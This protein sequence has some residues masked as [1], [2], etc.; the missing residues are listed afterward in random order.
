MDCSPPGSSV[1]GI[2]QARILEWVAMLS[3]KESSWTWGWTHLSC[4]FCIGRQIFY[5][6]VTEE[7]HH[8]PSDFPGGSDKPRKHMKKQRHYYLANIVKPLV[9]LVVMYGCENWSVKKSEDWGTDALNC[10]AAEDSWESLGLQGDQTRKLTLNIHRKDWY[11]NWSS[12]ILAT[13]LEELTHWKRPWVSER[14]KVKGEGGGRGWDGWIASPTQWTWVW[15][16]SRK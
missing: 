15:D 2:L 3:C 10:S 7:A 16:N 12:N 6:W 13:W 5:L 11:W 9:F 14:L 4:G 8:K 1:H